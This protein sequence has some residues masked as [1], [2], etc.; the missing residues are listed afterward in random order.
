[1]NCKSVMNNTW[2][3]IN[4][5]RASHLIWLSVGLLIPM[6]ADVL[7][8]HG[9]DSST[10]SAVMDTVMAAFSIIAVLSVRNWLND[11]MKHRGFDQADKCILYLA[12][13]TIKAEFLIVEIEK[14]Y[15][16]SE[17][18]EY[19]NN[20]RTYEGLKQSTEKYYNDFDSHITELS[21]ELK[22]LQLWNIE[23][24]AEK[25]PLLENYL[26][27]LLGF[28]NLSFTAMQGYDEVNKT[29]RNRNWKSLRTDL[30]ISHG[31]IQINYSPLNVSYN[32]LFKQSNIL[33][34]STN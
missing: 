24:T 10:V 3:F 33:A 21:L 25:K 17:D 14:T 29:S 15:G 18:K 1:M 23:F 13:A 30:N 9:I 7:F 4:K 20:N 31:L 19:L 8:I 22:L 12:K 2:T 5:T 6:Y 27:A 28:R 26:D 11:K 16:Y 32:K 34:G